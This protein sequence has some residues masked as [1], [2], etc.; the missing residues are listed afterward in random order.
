MS[1]AWKDDQARALILVLS[2]VCCL[3]SVV[4]CR[5]AGIGW[6]VLGG[7]CR[8]PDG[9]VRVMD[10]FVPANSLWT[11]R[12]RRQGRRI[13]DGFDT[14]IID[15]LPYAFGVLLVQLRNGTRIHV[16]GDLQRVFDG[17]ACGGDGVGHL[18]YGCC[19]QVDA[20]CR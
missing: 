18:G 13:M 20:R 3:L 11:C 15:G 10:S 7:W 19:L 4:W 6:L 12:T 16:R 8:V 1:M 17:A 14:G 5:M 9:W 2:V